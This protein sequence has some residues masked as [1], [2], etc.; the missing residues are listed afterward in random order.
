MIRAVD[1]RSGAVTLRQLAASPFE[2]LLPHVALLK[3]SKYEAAFFDAGACARRCPLVVVT[4]GP[5]GCTLFARG[6]QVQVPAFEVEEVDPTGAGDAFLAAMAAGLCKGLP[7]A[8]AA[9]M[10]NYFGALT[11]ASVGVPELGPE[12]F[13]AWDAVG[14]TQ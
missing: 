14:Q 9:L 12:D 4:D 1:R 10:G 8:K 6:E 11:A 13:A 5:L 3:A 2:E 7:P